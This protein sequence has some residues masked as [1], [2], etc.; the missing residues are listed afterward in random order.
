MCK[1]NGLRP[2][3]IKK[4]LLCGHMRHYIFYQF[5]GIKFVISD[6]QITLHTKFRFEV[7][8]CVQ[9]RCRFSNAVLYL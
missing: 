5:F 7:L 2:G 1:W 9:E 8:C 3:T 4:Q 6:Q